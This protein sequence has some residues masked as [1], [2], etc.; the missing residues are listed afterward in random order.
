MRAVRW[1]LL[2]AMVTMADGQ[3]R[4]L[5]V[6]G[7]VSSQSGTW[8]ST[9]CD[10]ATVVNRG[11]AGSKATDWSSGS[12]A[13]GTAGDGDCRFASAF[14]PTPNPP[15]TSVVLWAG[16]QDFLTTEGCALTRADV[17]SRVTAAVNALKAAAPAGTTIIL[18]SYCMASSAM[19]DGVLG[20]CTTI[21]QFNSLNGGIQDAANADS[22]VTFIDSVGA[23]G[24]STSTYSND[25]YL[26]S[27]VAMNIKGY[28][29]QYTMPAFTAALQCG[30]LGTD[31]F[32]CDLP[33][34]VYGPKPPHTFPV[35]SINL[36]AAAPVEFYKSP[37]VVSTGTYGLTDAHP[38]CG[39]LTSD[40]GYLM[41]GKAL[42]AGGGGITRS[43]AVKLS[44]AGA[45]VWVWKST[46][47]A[48]GQKDVANAVL[49]LPN[50]GDVLVIGFRGVAGVFQRSITKLAI[51]NGAEA[52]TATWPATNAAHHGAWENAEL[53]KDGTAVILAGLTNA[54]DGS[55]WQFKSCMHTHQRSNGNPACAPPSPRA[56]LD[57]VSR[58]F[59][60]DCV[61]QMAT[62][63]RA[64]ASYRSCPSLH[65]HLLQ[66]R[67]PSLGRIFRPITTRSR[68]LARSQMVRS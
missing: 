10:S 47:A 8:I 24:G 56:M 36:A 4:V 5:Q 35:R 11:V 53:T 63:P 66:R 60:N 38:V 44:S 41:A 68:V 27:P 67:V 59:C 40:G 64:K 17:A 51:S 7:S 39:G 33:A 3:P 19:A 23:C 61:S 62:L 31:S 16:I 52:F 43:Y 1:A 13:C 18:P 65:F 50:G 46:G 15:Y 34:R 42:E 55:S 20:Y 32:N 28:C 2:Y 37:D 26:A 58:R 30:D 29:K 57:L 21:A 22:S 9:F 6:G 49:Q 54:A 48:D 25:A 12:T 14:S 45:I